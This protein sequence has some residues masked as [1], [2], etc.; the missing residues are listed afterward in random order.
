MKVLFQEPFAALLGLSCDCIPKTLNKI[1]HVRYKN[2]E[3]HTMLTATVKFICEVGGVVFLHAYLT[4]LQAVNMSPSQ[5]DEVST[6][7]PPQ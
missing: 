3:R 6:A 1:Q 4:K 2:D 7:R 5:H